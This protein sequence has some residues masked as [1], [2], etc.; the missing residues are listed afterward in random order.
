LGGEFLD[1]GGLEDLLVFAG[2]A[3]EAEG[4]ADELAPG[5]E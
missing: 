5:A 1:V 3:A 2:D 4:G